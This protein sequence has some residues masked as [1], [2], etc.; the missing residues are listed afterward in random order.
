MI[1]VSIVFQKVEHLLSYLLTYIIVHTCKM[2]YR[3][4]YMSRSL[5][6]LFYVIAVVEI[7]FYEFVQLRGWAEEWSEIFLHWFFMVNFAIA[8]ILLY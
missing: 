8:F 7:E 4:V 3:V 5:Q 2:V 1:L 6:T